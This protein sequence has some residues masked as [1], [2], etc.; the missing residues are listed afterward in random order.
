MSSKL[1]GWKYDVM[2]FES[3]KKVELNDWTKPVKLNRK[4]TRRN[5][6]S[7]QPAQQAVGHMV[8]SDG[9]LVLGQD[10]KVVMVDAQGRPVRADPPPGG[11]VG[12]GKDEKGKDGK[13]KKKSKDD[14]GKKKSKDDKKKDDKKAKVSTS[15][16]SQS[17][18]SL[19][20]VNSNRSR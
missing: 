12:G 5:D 18:F 9:K 3:R 2:K 1:N 14:K 11:G 8:G 19:F 16:N 20:G 6:P 4:D 7:A 17:N 10:G 13:D 15:T